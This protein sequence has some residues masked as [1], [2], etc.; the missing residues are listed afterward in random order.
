MDRDAG[1]ARDAGDYLD[2]V[3]RDRSRSE[4]GDDVTDEAATGATGTV[5]NSVVGANVGVGV[6]GS[7]AGA[8]VGQL[9]AADVEQNLDTGVENL[10][11]INLD[12]LGAFAKGEDTG[13][14]G[15]P[16]AESQVERA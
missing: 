7:L 4:N 14:I 12:A 10:E 13:A 15:N 3:S 9:T 8:L 2:D 1:D 11:P 16:I 6:S 5:S